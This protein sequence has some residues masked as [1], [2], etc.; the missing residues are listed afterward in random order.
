[1]RI[2]GRGV[3]RLPPGEFAEV[4]VTGAGDYDLRARLAG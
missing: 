1:V 3:T 2:T 4:E